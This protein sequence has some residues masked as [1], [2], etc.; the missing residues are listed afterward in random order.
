M[1]ISVFLAVIST[2]GIKLS[3]DGCNALKSNSLLD[4][5]DVRTRVESLPTE[6][7]T[8][9]VISRKITFSF[10]VEKNILKRK[11]QYEHGQR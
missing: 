10:Y 2:V 9:N 7:G 11:L 1:Q 4:L 6:K 8:N 5:L 3:H